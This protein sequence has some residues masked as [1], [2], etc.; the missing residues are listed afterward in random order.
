MSINR[1]EPDAVGACT[2]GR[3]LRKLNAASDVPRCEGC[4]YVAE[5]CRCERQAD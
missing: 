3:A 1:P 5:L 2:C 4:G